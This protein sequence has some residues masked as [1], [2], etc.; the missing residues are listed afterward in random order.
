VTQVFIG[1]PRIYTC[2]AI[3]NLSDL[4]AP[5]MKIPSLVRSS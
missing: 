3:S 2:L 4:L 1:T 5:E